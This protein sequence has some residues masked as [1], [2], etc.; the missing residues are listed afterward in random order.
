MIV[1]FAGIVSI[2]TAALLTAWSAGISAG[3]APAASGAARMPAALNGKPAA[4]FV[5]LTPLDYLEIR[6]L[7]ARYAYAV[8]T[9]AENGDVYASLFSPDGAFA[10]RTGRETKGRDALAALARR[11]TR[12]QQSAFHFIVNHVIEPSPEGAVGKQYLLQLRIGDGERPNDVFGGGHYDD[13]YV[14]TPGG[15]RFKRRQFIPSEGS[16]SPRR[17]AE[18]R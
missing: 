3:Q 15:W 11:N 16:P 4:S 6:Q 8:D 14:K 10:D 2:A 18:A 1:R 7:V 17:A 12:G 5:G 13:V 9:G